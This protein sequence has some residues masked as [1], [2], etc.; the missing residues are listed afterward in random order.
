[1][2]NS[3]VIA[4]PTGRPGPGL[5]VSD[6]LWAVSGALSTACLIHAQAMVKAV[7]PDA[8]RGR[9]MGW[10]A[11][12][13]YAA[14]GVAILAAGVAV[15]KIGLFHTVA[16]VGAVGVVCAVGLGVWCRGRSPQR[17]SETVKT[18]SHVVSFL[19]QVSAAARVR[20]PR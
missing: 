10:V 14:Q 18:W 8:R 20:K 17:E 1:M 11:T 7:V 15:D 9:V 5:W 16:L 4:F 13:L 3:S 12:S 2:E 19:K 6:G